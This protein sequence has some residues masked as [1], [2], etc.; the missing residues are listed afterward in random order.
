MTIISNR[1]VLSCIE[2]NIE[3]W[4]SETGQWNITFD[5]ATELMNL[6]QSDVK[7]ARSLAHK[8]AR[9]GKG[10]IIS[11]SPKVFIPLTHLCRDYCGYCTFR[12]DPSEMENPYM[13]V[14]Q[15]L[16]VVAKGT[17]AGCT[18]ALFTLGER[19]ELKYPEAKKWLESEG[20]NTTL[21]Y[22]AH[23]SKIVNSQTPMFPHVNP[24]TMSKREISQFKDSNVSMGL[25][26]ESISERM[27][28]TGM[29]HEFAPSK[30]P[31]ARLKT[32][33]SAGILKVPFTTGLLLGLGETP[34]E[35]IEGLYALKE[36]HAKFGHIQ[37]VILQN[38][39]AKPGTPMETEKDAEVEYLSWAIIMTRLILGPEANIQVPPNLSP[40][41]YGDYLG[42]GINDW[43]GISPVTVDY[44]NPEAKW[45]TIKTLAKVCSDK[46][47]VL[48]PRFPIYPEFI[49][50]EKGY[51]ESDLYDKVINQCD[52]DGY[53][54]GGLEPYGA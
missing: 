27:F 36:L 6:S 4:E 34:S 26:L 49:D 39:R 12:K 31:T 20:F 28:L 52:S 33:E 43:G 23:I 14:E 46:G 53:V 54:I 40:D 3:D 17:K 45:P 1:N 32:L 18:E 51:I 10:D 16:E 25:M 19:P 41:M 22:L 9:M 2:K 50:L 29:P 48:K 11:F 42:D 24:G 44:V 7:K 47:Y 13:N 37:E 21:G 35:V 8:T 15:V 38:F 30:R 5:Q